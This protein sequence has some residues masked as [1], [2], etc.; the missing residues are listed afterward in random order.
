MQKRLDTPKKFPD[1]HNYYE[2]LMFTLDQKAESIGLIKNCGEPN[3]CVDEARDHRAGLPLPRAKPGR[4][5]EI[6][7]MLI[8]L[9][10]SAATNCLLKTAEFSRQSALTQ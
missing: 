9:R 1:C 3:E 10:H 4:I 2:D 5:A 7:F 6:P 8:R